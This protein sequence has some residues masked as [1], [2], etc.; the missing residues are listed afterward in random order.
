MIGFGTG[1]TKRTATLAL[2]AEI[3]QWRLKAQGKANDRLTCCDEVCL[4]CCIGRQDQA[5][6]VAQRELWR[7]VERLEVPHVARVLSESGLSYTGH[8]S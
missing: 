2:H 4:G 5:R 3:A 7:D 1:C 6:A 8:G